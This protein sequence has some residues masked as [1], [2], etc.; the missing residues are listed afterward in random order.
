M[1]RY[2]EI[3]S[4][5]IENRNLVPKLGSILLAVILWAYISSAKSGDV[6]FKLPLTF[7]GLNENFVVSKISHK[8]AVVE[9]QG[10]KDDLKS[11]SSKNVKLLVDLSSAEPGEYKTYKIQYQK[12]DFTDDFQVEI[13]PEEVKILLERKTE[14]NVKIVPR[15]TGDTAKGFMAGKIRVNPEY[16]K[17]SGP[18]SVIHK[19]GVVYTDEISVDDKNAPFRQDVKIEKLNEEGLEYSLSKVVAAVP[20]INNTA[21]TVFEIPVSIRNKSRNYKYIY[22]TVKVKINV[23][24]SENKNLTDRSFSAYIDA[25]DIEIDNDE[26]QKKGK[27]EVK[28]FLHINGDSPEADNSILSTVP[29]SVEIVVTK[30]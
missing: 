18:E 14:R 27:I 5:I 8:A 12:I 3:L 25:D 2:I 24:V 23:L 9:V 29:D 17:I 21:V 15:Y 6:R 26:L 22:D 30:E 4:R 19:I 11:I 20:V 1:K 28:S 10:N 16:V 13:S 7:T